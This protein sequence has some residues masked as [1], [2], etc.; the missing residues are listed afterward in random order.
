MCMSQSIE[1]KIPF[2]LLKEKKILKKLHDNKPIQSLVKT[3]STQHINT[4]F[5]T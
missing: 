3:S 4:L 2:S 5:L 1:T